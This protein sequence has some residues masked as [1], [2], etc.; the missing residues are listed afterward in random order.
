M[1]CHSFRV[2][3]VQEVILETLESLDHRFASNGLSIYIE[4]MSQ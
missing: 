3:L 2:I 1:L 4:H